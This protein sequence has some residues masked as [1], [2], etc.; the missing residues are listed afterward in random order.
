MTNATRRRVGTS[1]AVGVLLA[2]LASTPTGS[3]S[4]I[5]DR[6][7]RVE[8]KIDSAEEHLDHSSAE[9]TVA[10]QRLAGAVTDLSAARTSL[11]RTNGE[12]AA[13]QALDRRMQVELVD[14]VEDL[15]RAR[16]ALATSQ[17]SVSRREDALRAIVAHQHASGGAG[18]MAI[19]TV[20]STQNTVDL[21][22]K[23]TSYESVLDAEAATLARLAAS[24]VTREVQ[25]S[26]FED[27]KREV[28]SR[29]AAAAANLADKAQLQA[30]AQ[31]TESEIEP[32]VALRTEARQAAAHARTEDLLQLE[33]LEEEKAEISALLRQR[34]EEAREA[35]EAAARAEAEREATERRDPPAPAPD[36]NHDAPSPSPA[37]SPVTAQMSYPVDGYLTS[38]YG[39]RFHPIYKQWKLHDG[40][41]FGAGCGT[42]VRAVTDGTVI[43]MY[44]NSGYGNRVIMDHGL[45]ASVGLGTTYNHLSGFST[46]VGQTVQQG[47]VIG[48]VGST[49][50]STGCHL[51][52]MVFE[53]GATVDPMSWL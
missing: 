10:D 49:G 35:A 48:Y 41:D 4:E 43:S 8:S 16:T 5:D 29:R 22:R 52:F 27:L 45:R 51:H 1:F 23:L 38:P 31:Q 42:P 25:E 17:A 40:T 26:A 2:M 36:E 53:D 19:S 28:A 21:T 33:Q 44:Y 32:L 34:A 20:L 39:M 24:Q 12:L 15:S 13:A 11:A 30:Q 3:A 18:L 46:F 47:D 14:A 7:D 9:L 6:K 37:P 50:A